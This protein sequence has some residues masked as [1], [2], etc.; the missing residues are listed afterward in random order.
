MNREPISPGDLQAALSAIVGHLQKLDGVQRIW[1][2]GSIAKG[3]T[4]D[5]RSDI[6][7]AVEG[8]ESSLLCRVWSEIDSL[9]KPP[10]DLVRYEEA[11]EAL[12]S[13]IHNWGRLL[14]VTL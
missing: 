12:R 2:F 14:H 11:S 8:L 13:E 5:W 4:P 6:D 1:L 3:R 9:I 10:L 7:I